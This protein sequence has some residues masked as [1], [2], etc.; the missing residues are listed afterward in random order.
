M[1]LPHNHQRF[2]LDTN[3]YIAIVH[4]LET[5]EDRPDPRNDSVVDSIVGRDLFR[6]KSLFGLSA[7]EAG[8][9]LLNHRSKQKEKNYTPQSNALAQWP[10]ERC[11]RMGFD[12]ESYD[13]W[14]ELVDEVKL[15]DP[16]DTAAW[17][18]YQNTRFELFVLLA[19]DAHV[20][21]AQWAPFMKREPTPHKEARAL[22]RRLP[23]YARTNGRIYPVS[24]WISIPI[25]GALKS[26]HD[27]SRA[28]YIYDPTLPQFRLLYEQLPRP[29]HHE[30]PVWYFLTGQ[31]SRGDKLM[32]LLKLDQL[33]EMRYASINGLVEVQERQC[34]ALV[35]P[36]RHQSWWGQDHCVGWAYRVKNEVEERR[37]RLFKTDFFTVV[38]CKILMSAKGR[39]GFQ[40]EV[41][42]LTF[43]FSGGEDMFRYMNSL[44]IASIPGSN[45]WRRRQ[46]TSQRLAPI[47][48]PLK[49]SSTTAVTRVETT[50]VPAMIINMDEA[51]APKKA[52]SSV[53]WWARGGPPASKA[54]QERL[55]A[56]M[57]RVDR[58][59]EATR[60]HSIPKLTAKSRLSAV[61]ELEAKKAAKP[62]EEAWWSKVKEPAVKTLARE[63]EALGDSGSVEH[64]EDTALYTGNFTALDLKS[65]NQGSSAPSQGESASTFAGTDVSPQ[66]SANESITWLN[67]Q[68]A[69]PPASRSHYM[70]GSS[71]W[72]GKN[73]ASDAEFAAM[74]ALPVQYATRLNA[75]PTKT[76]TNPA[77]RQTEANCGVESGEGGTA[78]VSTN[79][80]MNASSVGKGIER[81]SKAA[82]SHHGTFSIGVPTGSSRM[83]T[84][85]QRT[86]AS[87]TFR[88]ATSAPVTRQEHFAA[89]RATME[90]TATNTAPDLWSQSQSESP[91]W[92]AGAASRAA[93]RAALV[94][95]VRSEL[96]AI[97]RGLHI[98]RR[99]SFNGHTEL[100]AFDMY[101]EFGCES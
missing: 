70:A 77:L 22:Q 48:V 31:I 94:A 37:L 47:S 88:L 4:E 52:K 74:E 53:P 92:L 50:S 87:N 24:N 27:G 36:G 28:P 55:D 93:T 60:T 42:G 11:E 54:A 80:S 40:T 2:Y 16:K 35:E 34:R 75:T 68:L 29:L 23:R 1:T 32:R 20:D 97:S 43:V 58:Q 78:I 72:K 3:T 71:S 7:K 90:L 19:V 6:W 101:A 21:R 83:G 5:I 86:G 12:R 51:F 56:A 44:P 91:M 57:G 65:P 85:W 45:G 96:M 99:R 33:P 63:V 41:E 15:T 14:L 67:A 26:L 17:V 13:Y 10:W 49:A 46:K 95:Y 79:E 73:R 84:P 66:V 81:A 82:P 25:S 100:S 8:F 62:V 64:I 38:R 69:T 61:A 98:R 9:E 18:E 39:S 59:M 30:Y 89:N 76:P